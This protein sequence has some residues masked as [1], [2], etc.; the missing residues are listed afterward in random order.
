M[1]CVEDLVAF[2]LGDLKYSYQVFAE[3]LGS[4]DQ[5]LFLDDPHAFLYQ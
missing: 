3:P 5:D 4:T 1:F 2:V